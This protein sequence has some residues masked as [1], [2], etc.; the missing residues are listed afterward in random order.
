MYTLQ[1]LPAGVVRLVAPMEREELFRGTDIFSA[2]PDPAFLASLQDTMK[3]PGLVMYGPFNGLFGFMTRPALVLRKAIYVPA[4]SASVTFGRP[5]TTN[6][7][8]GRRCEYNATSGMAFWG[9][10]SNVCP[11]QAVMR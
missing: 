6:P 10:V 2:M 11:C 7:V 8:C 4:D 5:D 3:A 1:L 9:F